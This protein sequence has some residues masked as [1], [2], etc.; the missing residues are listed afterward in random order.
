VELRFV[1]DDDVLCGSARQDPG[2]VQLASR[3]RPVDR[4]AAPAARRATSSGQRSA[5]VVPQAQV[6]GMAAPDL[7]QP[8]AQ[9]DADLARLLGAQV[10]RDRPR[11]S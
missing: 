3:N 8:V 9:V 10:V 6:D 11:S 4:L 5:S 1:S 2:R 7:L